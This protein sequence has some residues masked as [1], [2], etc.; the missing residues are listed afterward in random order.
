MPTAYYIS[1]T[2]RLLGALLWLGGTSFL[3]VVGAPLP[4]GRAGLRGISQRKLVQSLEIDESTIAQWG[5]EPSRP[6]ARHLTR[7]QVPENL[8]TSFP[9]V[10]AT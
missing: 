7:L 9:E 4:N 8:T 6:N 2:L 1:V 5:H 3:G 10:L